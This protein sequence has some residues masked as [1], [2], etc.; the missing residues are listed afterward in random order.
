MAFRAEGEAILLLDA[1]SGWAIRSRLPHKI[2]FPS[3][4]GQESSEIAREFSSSEYARTIHSIE[5][6]APPVA[7]LVAEK[8]LI[9]ALNQLAAEDQIKSAH[10]VS[11]GGIAVTIAECCFA[12]E[13]FSAHV[14]LVSKNPDEAA[15][16]GER[17]SRA[18]VSVTPENVAAARQI[19]AQYEVAVVEV[20][21]VTRGG[22]FRIELN[23]QT[24]V[25]AD[26]PSL[27]DAWSGALERLLGANDLR[28]AE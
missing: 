1:D 9:S 2:Y 19:A 6:G 7:N 10:D 13:G 28:K 26:L 27:A 24:V 23:G 12:S 8:R 22:E 5:A 4:S 20:G 16:F 18:I 14:S 3:D 17:G 21:R 25:S 11:D 15:L